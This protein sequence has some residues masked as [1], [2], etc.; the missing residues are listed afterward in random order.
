MEEFEQFDFFGPA[1]VTAV[2]QRV[3][4]E[5]EIELPYWERDGNI[6]RVDLP[7]NRSVEITRQRDGR[8][9]GNVPDYGPLPKTKN[10]PIILSA[11]AKIARAIEIDD[12]ESELREEQRNLHRALHADLIRAKSHETKPRL[13]HKLAR[14]PRQEKL[15]LRFINPKSLMG[16]EPNYYFGILFAWL[17]NVPGITPVERVAYALMA[18]R[19]DDDGVF[20]RSLRRLAS[21]CGIS[22]QH[23]Q[24]NI[25]PS[26][27]ARPLIARQDRGPGRK[28]WFRFV[29]PKQFGWLTKLATQPGQLPLPDVAKPDSH[30]GQRRWP[31]KE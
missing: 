29:D 13:R 3:F 7:G 10:A 9:Y 2:V 1:D 26:M 27:M 23:L 16:S 22:R 18:F 6:I 24:H 11:L 20:R 19:A 15:E 30:T 5:R 14:E 25:I 8:L 21:D 31:P 28:D 4:R 17:N 12:I